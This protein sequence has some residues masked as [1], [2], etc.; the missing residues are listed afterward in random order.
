MKKTRRQESN[1]S[2]LELDEELGERTGHC[3]HEFLHKFGHDIV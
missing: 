2:Y 3:E 1:F